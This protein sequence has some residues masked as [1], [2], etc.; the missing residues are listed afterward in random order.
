MIPI[1]PALFLSHGRAT[2]GRATLSATAAAR[3]APLAR[4]V[5]R[6]SR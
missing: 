1:A 4:G 3:R 5:A 6:R 2:A